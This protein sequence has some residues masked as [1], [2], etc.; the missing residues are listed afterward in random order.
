MCDGVVIGS[1][2][3]E[4]VV[5]GGSGNGSGISVITKLSDRH[6]LAVLDVDILAD[7]QANRS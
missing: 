7:N 5:C 1:G 2:S 6:A 4:V 3:G